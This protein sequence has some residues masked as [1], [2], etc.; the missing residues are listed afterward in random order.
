[1]NNLVHD[2]IHIPVSDAVPTLSVS[3]VTLDVPGRYGPL[4]LRVTAP[5]AGRDLPVLL[6]SHGGGPSLYIPSKDGY[7]PLAGFYA[8]HGFAVIQPTHASSRV[9]GA[10]AGTRGRAAP[11]AVPCGG[12]DD[13]PRP[14]GR[15]RGADP[16][17]DGAGW[18]RRAWRWSG[19]LRGGRP[20][21][22]CSGRN[23][24]TSRIRRRPAS[25][26]AS[27]GSRRGCCWQPR[28]WAATA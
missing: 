17:P 14:A 18:I 4:E 11:L 21:A 10:P 20:R 26:C 15:D 6:I 12:H 19:I 25:A 23:S 13:D 3:P 27:R 2:A 5:V 28:A 7:A 22:C 16:G 8:E 9:G 24:P 1:M